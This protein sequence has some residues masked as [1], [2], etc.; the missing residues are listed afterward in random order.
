MRAVIL[1]ETGD[2]SKLQYINSQ[3]VPKPQDGQVLV[4]NAFAGINYIDT[5]YRTGLYPSPTGY[6]LILG[7]EAAG[8]IAAVPDPNPYNFALN[9]PVVW[10]KQGSYAEYTA[11]PSDR[12]IKLPANLAP[13]QAVGGFLMGMT[14][15][16]LIREAYPV[17]RGEAVLVHAAAGGVGLLLCQ[18]L[19]LAGAYTIGTAGSKEKCELAEQHGAD[20]TINY[21]EDKAWPDTVKE[22][23][24]GKGVDVVYD[25]V[26]KTTWEG[27][28][29]AVKRKGKV[30]YFGAASGP[31]PLMNIQ[32]LAAKNV[33]VMRATLMQYIV[34][35]EEL[36]GYASE[37]LGLIGEG[38]LKVNVHKAYG[39]E[40]AKKAQDDLEGRR[41]TGKL[42]LKL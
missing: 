30:V 33:S 18:L 26:G 3:P 42:L 24:D 38:K 11:V 20:K 12:V 39:L 35:R 5:Y 27:S 16:S 15:L 6:P 7:Q 2:S 23:T 41:T 17:K 29:E 13:D 25:S 14:A 28:L 40:E 36:E 21:N 34:T 4:K 19:K 31:V 22:L 32:R 8:T 9:D 1:P 37:V 10:I